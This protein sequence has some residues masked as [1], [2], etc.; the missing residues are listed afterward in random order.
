MEYFLKPWG[1]LGIQHD[2]S[3]HIGRMDEYRGYREYDYGILRITGEVEPVPSIKNLDSNYYPQIMTWN[4]NLIPNI[5]VGI[6]LCKSGYNT[7]VTC[8][9]GGPVFHFRNLNTVGLF[10]ILTGGI[11]SV[12]LATHLDMILGLSRVFLV[13][14]EQ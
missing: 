11:G 4:R 14:I 6:H 13:G 7:R 5:H 2:I 9:V 10:G 12:D 3:H 8:D 1:P